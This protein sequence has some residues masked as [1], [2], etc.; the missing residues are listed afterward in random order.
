[1]KVAHL[2]QAHDLAIAPHGPQQLHIHLLAA[3][4]NGLILEF[5]RE[6]TDPMHGQVYVH[7]VVINEDGTVSPPEV[8]GA[9][10]EPN[11]SALERYRVD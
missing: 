3:I 4:A 2:A 11:Y 5:Y 6:S 7:N 10:L 1:M 9:G 8:P